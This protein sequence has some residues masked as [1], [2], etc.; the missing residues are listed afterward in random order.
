M[1]EREIQHAILGG[2]RLLE[3]A[4]GTIRADTRVF[5][6]DVAGGLR[7]VCDAERAEF[8]VVGSRG[9]SSLAA[10]VL[11][12]VSLE[13]AGTSRCPVVVVPPGA[14]ERF[15]MRDEPGGS[16]ICGVAGSGGARVLGVAECLAERLRLRVV[17]VFADSRKR[18]RH[19][20]RGGRHR[21]PLQVDIGDPVAVIRSRAVESHARLIVV[22]ARRRGVSGV[23]VLGSVSNAVAAA[24]PVPVVVVSPSAPQARTFPRQQS[25]D[26]C[27]A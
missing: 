2:A 3:R 11:G 7:S 21:L 27:D 12:S 13:M 9:R 24:A 17:P 26:S 25:R 4:A 5:I 6:G 19:H 20:R 14:G 23:A 8:L 22:G 16:I 15:L 10:A 18:V 1:R